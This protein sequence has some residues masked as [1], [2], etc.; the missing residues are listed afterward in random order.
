[1]TVMA[2]YRLVRAGIFRAGAVSK[3]KRFFSDAIAEAISI[4]RTADINCH[5]LKL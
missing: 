4:F 3:L 1:M 5:T 2:Y